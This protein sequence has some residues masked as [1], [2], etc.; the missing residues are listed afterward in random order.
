MTCTN[1][2][3]RPLCHS[4]TPRRSLV[5]S[6]YRPPSSAASCDLVTGRFGS[7]CSSKVQQR[8]L[9]VRV[10]PLAELAEC[11]AGGGRGYLSIGAP[12]RVVNTSPVS[13][14]ALP[15]RARSAPLLSADRELGSRRLDSLM[16]LTGFRPTRF[17]H[18]QDLTGY[19]LPA[20]SDTSSQ[21][22]RIRPVWHQAI[23]D[24]F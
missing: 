17:R 21:P 1:D 6:Q 23:L 13:I 12:W 9:G 11:F 24:G 14:Q 19:L 10:E 15:A 3:N 8:G 20:L 18:A 22:A 2:R 5:R 16:A 7:W 4:F